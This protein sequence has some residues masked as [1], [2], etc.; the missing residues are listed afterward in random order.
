MRFASA[1]LVASGLLAFAKAQQ[2]PPGQPPAVSP[3]IGLQ[4]GE[5]AP[6]FTLR[7]QFGREQSNETL[8]GANG[9]VLLFFRS[10][11]W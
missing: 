1:I 2:P 7:D 3:S 10:A 6:A 4:V 9:T 11:D 8:R 5:K